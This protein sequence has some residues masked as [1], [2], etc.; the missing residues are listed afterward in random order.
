MLDRLSHLEEN[1]NGLMQRKR[2]QEQTRGYVGRPIHN[3]LAAGE[4]RRATKSFQ[5]PREH[6]AKWLTEREKMDIRERRRHFFDSLHAEKRR[7][8]G[9]AEEGE[10]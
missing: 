3:P 4:R 9:K 1:I 8:A 2:A 6:S 7:R 5:I 10:A